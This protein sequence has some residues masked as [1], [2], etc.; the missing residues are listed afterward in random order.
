MEFQQLALYYGIGDVHDFSI[1]NVFTSE[2]KK[3][4]LE[5]KSLISSS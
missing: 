2:M 5:K 4:Q 3:E 1:S